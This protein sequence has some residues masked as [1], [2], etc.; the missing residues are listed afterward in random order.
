M[1]LSGWINFAITVG[2]FVAFLIIV[3]YYYNPWKKKKDKE[4]VEKP[5]YTM[6]NDDEEVKK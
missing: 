1:H 5:K 6:L 4:K 3:F 2:L